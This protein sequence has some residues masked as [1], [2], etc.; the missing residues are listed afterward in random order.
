MQMT[1]YQNTNDNN[2][3]IVQCT[4]DNFED[5]KYLVQMF[6]Q[7]LDVDGANFCLRTFSLDGTM[8]QR[9]DEAGASFWQESTY[10]FAKSATGRK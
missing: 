9:L 3:Y 7:I 2:H 5:V 8:K 1:K 6:C 4:R 10:A